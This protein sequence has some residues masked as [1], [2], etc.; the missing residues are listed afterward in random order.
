M[1]WQLQLV[2]VF[3]SLTN[4]ALTASLFSWI[5]HFVD[6]IANQGES[7][8]Q[9]AKSW[10]G[11]P[12]S[13]AFLFANG[14]IGRIWRM[15]SCGWGIHQRNRHHAGSTLRF[16]TIRCTGSEPVP[17]HWFRDTSE[18]QITIFIRPKANKHRIYVL[19]TQIKAE[20][21]RLV[22]FR[23]K[24]TNADAT[25]ARGNETADLQTFHLLSLFWQVTLGTRRWARQPLQRNSF[26]MA[27]TK[28]ADPH[29][30]LHQDSRL[31]LFDSRYQVSF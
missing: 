8:M 21:R 30:V 11:K 24:K 20:Q 6:R 14:M 15:H 29:Q 31:G 3:L 23:I 2:Q 28:A 5:G 27:V 10:S 18:I 7:S 9:S 16:S 22:I 13:T 26:L 12:K 4:V 25:F 17:I 19:L 1:P